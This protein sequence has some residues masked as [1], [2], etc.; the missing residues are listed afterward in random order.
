MSQITIQCRLVANT[1]TYEAFWKLMA[2]GNT[3]LI[4]ELLHQICQH[5]DFPT[6]REKGKIPGGLIKQLC[7]SL[8]TDPRF[9]DQ[10]GRFYM[11][12][13]ALVE[14]ICK[15]WLKRQQ[16][17]DFQLKAKQRWLNQ[18]KTDEQ[19]IEESQCSLEQI[20]TKASEILASLDSNSDRMRTLFILNDNTPESD[21]LTQTAI[22]Y[23]LKN[24]GR[25]PEDIEDD[26]KLAKGRRKVE[27]QIER[28][29]EQL[30][31]RYPKG[32]D[33][34]GQQW[35]DTLNLAIATQPKNNIEAKIWQDILL[36]QTQDLPFPVAY[37]TNEDL[38]WSKNEKGRLFVQF[39]GLSQHR[40]EIYCDQ[41]QLKYFQR[42]YDDQ[43]IKRS[44]KN[45]HSS[46]LFILRSGRIAWQQGTGKGQ[47]W[48][49]HTLALYCTL[50]TRLWTAEGTEQVRQQKAIEVSQIL[51]KMNEKE[52]L[53]QQQQK[54][55]QR[56][57][58]TLARLDNPFPRPSQ[59]LYSGQPH[60]LLGVAMGLEHPATVAIVDVTTEQA[61]AYRSLKQLLGDNYKLLNRQRQQKRQL[62]QQRRKSQQR[63]NP[64]QSGES[65][66]GEYV[67]R[68]LAKAIVKLAESYRVG[69]I[70]LPQLREIRE[71]LQSE[72]QAK[73]EQKIPGYIEGQKK[74]AKEYRVNVHQWSYGRLRE[75]IQAQAA[76]L[77]IVIEDG[78]QPLEG[79]PQ[80]KARDMAI[81]TYYHRTQ[82]SVT[83]KN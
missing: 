15:S 27:I 62:S 57:N 37:E 12:A 51:T 20:R 44:S 81:A 69:S 60:L 13:I 26:K 47:P 67:D 50:D 7:N 71:Q 73:A 39:N 17:L 83:Q 74:Y 33:L 79:S 30:E 1:T 8:K 22:C 29:T 40:F 78:K 42:F 77:G 52:D 72:I 59:P 24:Y 14:R 54:F 70:V 43:Q 61:I 82:T 3:P 10:P 23:L 76:K 65:Q 58:S 5:P 80:E 49:I 63:A 48:E 32:R 75:N 34:T 25:M 53:T 21:S 35:L 31:S 6:W 46:A 64:D 28:L 19:L 9:Q 41:R 38:T 11:S 16:R 45:Q 55:I 36:T 4:N 56:K 18:L 68:L 66:L 2:E